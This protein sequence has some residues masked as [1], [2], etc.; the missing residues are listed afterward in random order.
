MR[1]VF[2]T[3]IYI[4]ARLSF[5]GDHVWC[6]DSFGGGSG[7]CS[8]LFHLPQFHTLLFLCQA[9]ILIVSNIEGV[10]CYLCNPP[11]WQSFY[12]VKSKC[13]YSNL[14]NLTCLLLLCQIFKLLLLLTSGKINLTLTDA[15]NCISMVELNL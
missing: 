2:S 4:V 14:H 5:L 6:A 13:Y 10:S 7:T 3:L 9:G 12:F 15:I 11:C 8:S 1:K